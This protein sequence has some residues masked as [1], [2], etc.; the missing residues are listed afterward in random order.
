MPLSD[1]ETAMLAMLEAKRN[2]PT[3][4]VES[5]D[6]PDVAEVAATTAIA[7]ADAVADTTSE[8]IRAAND[9]AD[10]LEQRCAE[11]ERRLTEAVTTPTEVTVITEPDH[12][13]VENESGDH[14][15]EGMTQV[16][17]NN[18]A[19]AEI[20]IEGEIEEDAT[21]SEHWWY[22]PRWGY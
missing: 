13:D 4:V 7:V 11:L 18:D 1:D 6:N 21:P 2:E 22:K 12:V 10:V 9:R 15:E 8:A 20:E 3:P 5:N 17:E 16:E 14:I 19:P